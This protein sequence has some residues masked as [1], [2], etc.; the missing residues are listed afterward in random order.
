MY[1]L[2]V[3]PK[4]V[5]P[6]KEYPVKMKKN[7]MRKWYKSTQARARVRLSRLIRSWNAQNLNSS[8]I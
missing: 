4:S 5:N 2:I 7:T 1:C 8:I 6:I 3:L